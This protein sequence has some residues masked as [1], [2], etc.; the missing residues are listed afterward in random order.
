MKIAQL[1]Y[2]WYLLTTERCITHLLK[3]VSR[4]NT[5]SN[6]TNPVLYLQWKHTGLLTLWVVSVHQF[7]L[8]LL[9]AL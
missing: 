3:I 2:L 9:S 7:C 1:I 8:I 4:N 5:N 6:F